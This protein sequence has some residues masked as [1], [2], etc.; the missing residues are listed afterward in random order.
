MTD[1]DPKAQAD[2]ANTDAGV[3]QDG[4]DPAAMDSTRPD[5]TA[6]AHEA[7]GEVAASDPRDVEI[8]QLREENA[9]LRDQA[10]RALADA[11]NT[12]R[13]AERD[14]EDAAKFGI[15]KFARD[16]L[17]VSDNFRRALEYAP[18]K[19]GADEATR[20]LIGGI[21]AT[22]SSMLQ[23]FERHGLKRLDPVDE[24]FDPNYHE[25][26]SEV[27]GTGKVPGT[28]VQT[29]QS[30]FVLNGRL[31]RPARVLIAKGDP[32]KSVDETA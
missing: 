14:K 13:R 4:T 30:G 19:E 6:A 25:A 3:G 2:A 10:L 9:K 23:V 21:E 27:P 11:E 31:L 15:S 1:T 5:A 22:E 29:I 7:D 8:A 18:D 20:N 32:P 24:K 28:V 12:R 16:L 17:E 26:M